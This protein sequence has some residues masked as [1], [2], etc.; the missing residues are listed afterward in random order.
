MVKGVHAW[1]KRGV[2][3]EEVG[4]VVK[5]ACVVVG[6]HAWLGACVVVGGVHGWWGAYVVAGGVHVCRGVSVVAGGRTWDT[7]RYDQ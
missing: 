1:R 6:G 7:T 2:Q 4:C 5:G 3:G